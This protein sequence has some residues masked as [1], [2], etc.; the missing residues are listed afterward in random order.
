LRIQYEG[1]ARFLRALT[2]FNIVRLWGN[3]PLILQPITTQEAYSQVRNNAS[4]IYSAIEADL[5][6]AEQLPKKY[7]D[8]ADL[9]RATSGA[10]KVLLAKVYLT[11]RKQNEAVV[12]LEDLITNYAEV[13]GLQPTPED[14]FDVTKKMNKEIV[15]AVRFSKTIPG[16]NSSTHDAYTNKFGLDAALL[17]GYKGTD[18]RKALL[19]Y[20]RIN[21]TFIV[22]KYAEAPDPTTNNIGFDFPVLRW[23]D[24][25]LM[26]AEALN[27]VG[28]SSDETGAAFTALN[29]VRSRATASL[30]NNTTLTDQS[31]FREAVLLER[32]LELPLENHRWF[33][34]LR[35][36]KAIDAMKV[37]KLDI[38]D[39]DL[40]YPIPES[41]VLIMNNPT[42]FP[43]NPGYE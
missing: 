37:V 32:R 17:S 31:S 41:E 25:L 5:I 9:G 35:T 22:K 38:T 26:Y 24:V 28:Y 19:G 6:F 16:E 12:L 23:A 43:Q 34:L 30:Y 20:T 39:N 11:Q 29:A 7:A 2:Y 27:E 1:E 21:S 4:E 14:I 13:Y 33:D 10:A 3:A 36:G 42:G 40:L 15:F 18:K 8:D